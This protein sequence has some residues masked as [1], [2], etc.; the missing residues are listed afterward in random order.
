MGNLLHFHVGPP[1]LAAHPSC[2][3]VDMLTNKSLEQDMNIVPWLEM[4]QADVIDV[5]SYWSI[6]RVKQH[7][8]NW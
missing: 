1:D 2:P 6:R 3:G 5:L 7:L 8:H 4:A